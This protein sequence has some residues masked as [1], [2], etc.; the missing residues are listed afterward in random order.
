MRM[1]SNEDLTEAYRAGYDEAR[2]TS[3]YDPMIYHEVALFATIGKLDLIRMVRIYARCLPI[4]T[5]IIFR[6]VE[7]LDAFVGIWKY[8]KTDEWELWK[9]SDLSNCKDRTLD[10]AIS[11]LLEYRQEILAP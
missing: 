3:A 10:N 8:P 1:L 6:F 9:V 2:E 11:N 7:N 5:G 4:E